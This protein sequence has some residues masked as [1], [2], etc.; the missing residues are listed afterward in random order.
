MLYVV[1]VLCDVYA[2]FTR[3]GDVPP[4]TAE[5]YKT[6]DRHYT[7]HSVYCERWYTAKTQTTNWHTHYLHTTL[8]SSHTLTMLS[9]L[10]R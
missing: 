8:H 5:V 2:L 1:Y 9:Y 10:L 4:K 6:Q 7:L 3:I